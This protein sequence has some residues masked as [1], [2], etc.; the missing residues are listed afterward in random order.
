MP[1]NLAHLGLYK[2][3]S[4]VWAW[5][6]RLACLGLTH[7]H[8]HI[9]RGHPSPLLFKINKL[10]DMSPAKIDDVS[11]VCLQSSYHNDG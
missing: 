3:S 10:G 2:K 8:T 11:H 9:K 5:W 7:T 6:L 4:S 1:N